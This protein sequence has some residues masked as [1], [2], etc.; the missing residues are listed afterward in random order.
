MNFQEKH[1]D[2]SLQDRF[3]VCLCV[4]KKMKRYYT[5]V[6]LYTGCPRSILQNLIFPIN[7]ERGTIYVEQHL[8]P[9]YSMTVLLFTNIVL[10]RKIHGKPGDPTLFLF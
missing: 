3:P 5:T 10:K 1:P 2:N 7:Y 8:L 9:L 4:L 6:Y